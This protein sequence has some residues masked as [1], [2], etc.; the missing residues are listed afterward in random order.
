[1]QPDRYHFRPRVRWIAS[2]PPG[3]IPPRRVRQAE[4]YSGP[5]SYPLMPRWGFPNLTWREPTLVPGLPAGYPPPIERIGAL[6]RYTVT[7]LWCLVGL[8]AAGAVGEFWRYALLVISRDAALGSGV[9]GASDA[10]VIAT[11][12]LAVVFGAMSIG[13][14]LWW[15]LVA[16]QAAA[17]GAGQEQP[18]STREVLLGALVPGLNLVMA[19]SI[20]A[21]LEHM[22]L[23][24]APDERP[25]PS[26]PVLV[27]WAAWVLNELCLIL[28]VIWRFWGGL[29]AQA[30]AVF[31][32]GLGDLSAA[33]LAG[34]TAFVVS[35]MTGLLAP[36]P[37]HRL[38]VRR[39]VAVA[40]APPPAG[41][42]A[43]PAGASR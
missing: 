18:R 34:V 37:P 22:V 14:T 29:Q 10:L 43:R 11:S 4:H 13:F 39:V 9:V 16:R 41:R 21:E 28:V 1:M 35:R 42:P 17:D 12:L 15:L 8:A 31:L 23:R 36:I 3:A 32:N 40:G 24:R 27:W 30:D 6:G 33:A 2:P 38:S 26:R 19:G 5:P 7:M 25:R 20:L